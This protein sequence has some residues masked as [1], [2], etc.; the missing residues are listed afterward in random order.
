MWLAN[1][2]T[3]TRCSA[4]AMISRSAC[5]TSA[6]ERRDAAALGVGGVA[7]CSSIDAVL[8][9]L[10][11]RAVVGQPA[12]D[13][14]LVELEVAG[15]Q[16]VADRRADEDADAVGDRV[17]HREEVEA[18]ARRAYTWPPALTSRSLAS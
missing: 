17:V 6:S 7:T 13:R 15:V 18:E 16:H 1:E 5:P 4:S 9:E 3:M 12:V 11:E 14:R 10:G 8:A 2:A